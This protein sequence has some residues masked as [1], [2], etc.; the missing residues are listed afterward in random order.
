MRIFLVVPALLGLFS[1]AGCSYATPAPECSKRPDLSKL[2]PAE[3]LA[4]K[5]ALLRYAARCNRQDYQCDVSL[6][7]NSQKEILVTVASVYPHR[8]SG[9]CVPAFGDQDLGVYSPAGT[10]IRRVMSL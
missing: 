1:L 5:D 4:L 10:F 7:R 2:D 6:I 3:R 9:H 8:A